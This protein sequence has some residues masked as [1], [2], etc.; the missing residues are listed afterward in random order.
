[1]LRYLDSQAHS[2]N[3][4]KC[5]SWWV[6]LAKI[7]KNREKKGEEVFERQF[8]G[9]KPKCSLRIE[10]GIV[11]VRRNFRWSKREA[12]ALKKQF[13][14]RYYVQYER[15]AVN[16]THTL[17][18]FWFCVFIVS[19]D[20]PFAWRSPRTTHRTVLSVIE[21]LFEK[22]KLLV[23]QTY[24]VILYAAVAAAVHSSL[25]LDDNIDTKYETQSVHQGSHCT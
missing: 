5:T 18:L 23:A 16:I 10:V 8:A 4:P 15:R 3:V 13:K 6:K 7:A 20:N 14:L 24:S 22:R 25:K 11:K 17:C 2:I 19:F 12:A 21:F 1:M 9:G